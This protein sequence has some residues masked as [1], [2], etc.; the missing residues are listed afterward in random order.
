MPGP[1]PN[2]AVMI[3]SGIKY[4]RA[5]KVVSSSSRNTKSTAVMDAISKKAS[6]YFQRLRIKEELCI[7]A[8][9]IIYLLKE[10]VSHNACCPAMTLPMKILKF[11]L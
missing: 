2:R 5:I 7:A 3:P 8:K 10:I 11:Y 9:F 1:S 4:S 6:K